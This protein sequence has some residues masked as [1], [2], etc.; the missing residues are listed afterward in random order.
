[1]PES[2]RDRCSRCYEHIFLLTKSRKYFFDR[3]LSRSRWPRLRR[4]V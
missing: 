3:K 4:G 2:V 1:M